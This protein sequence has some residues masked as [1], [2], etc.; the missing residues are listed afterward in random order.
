MNAP[1]KIMVVEN[2]SIVAFN[3]QQRL[4]HLGYHVCAVAASGEEALRLADVTRPDLV[5]MDIRIRG[6]MDGIEVASRLNA[7]H[8]L[9]VIY[10]TSHSEDA[11]IERART[12]R[13]C[14]YLLKPYS[15]REMHVTILMALERWKADVEP[16]ESATIGGMP[17]DMARDTTK[18][19]KQPGIPLGRRER[20]VLLLIVDGQP[21]K[22]I[23]AK[24][25]ITLATVGTHRRNIMHKL[26]L[27]NVADLTKYA[28]LC[29]RRDQNG[30]PR[31]IKEIGRASCRERV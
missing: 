1:V 3:L 20:A 25:N 30:P 15:D 10:L 31:A 9:P 22:R 12:T 26:D 2:E 5:L 29:S 6:E 14:G 17:F 28:L 27:H 21:S 8:P 16:R 24:L 23:A 18:L 13:P 19:V 7:S 11:T 4:S